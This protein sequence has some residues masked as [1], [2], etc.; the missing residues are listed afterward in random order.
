[1]F[2][3]RA[4]YNESESNIQN[5]YLLYKIDHQCQTT[6]EC[7]GKIKTNVPK[8]RKKT[9]CIGSNS[10]NSFAIAFMIANAKVAMRIKTI[11]L[12]IINKCKINIDD[13]FGKG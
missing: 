13:V 4:K 10:L 8:A 3:C 12:E 9:T 11:P 7:V 1:M 5:N 2:P 6:L